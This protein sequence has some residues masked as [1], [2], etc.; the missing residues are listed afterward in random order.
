MSGGDER[1]TS[2]R[3]LT[4]FPLSLLDDKG[5]ILDRHAVA[6]DVSDKGFKIET[7]AELKTG[8]FVRFGLSL[9]AD[10]D[11]KG[12]ARIVWCERTDLSY[13][14]G[15]QFLSMSWR[16]RRRVRRITS[17][18]DVDWNLLADKAIWALSILLVTIVGWKLLQ[19][20]LWREVLGGLAPTALAALAMGWA[21][22]ELL[23][24]G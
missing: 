23:R 6:H 10:G 7:M 22:R 8:Q 18:S 19:S 12:R 13:W 3:I 14:A 15:G 2:T 11:I 21:L 9:D 16:D 5:E 24:R 1:R 4:E 17:P 20:P